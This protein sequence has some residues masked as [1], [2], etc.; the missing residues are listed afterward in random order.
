MNRKE[1]TARPARPAC[2]PSDRRSGPDTA[3]PSPYPLED[4]DA[5]G[6]RAEGVV[7]SARW[8]VRGVGR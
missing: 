1:Q 4:I 7:T 6:L 3:P 2:P 5:G 8:H